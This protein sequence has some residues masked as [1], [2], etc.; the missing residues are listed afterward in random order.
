MSKLSQAW[1][2]GAW[3]VWGLLPLAIL[4]WLLSSLRRWCY[5]SGILSS[6]KP[7]AFIIVIGNIS[8][9]GNG[10]TP[11]VIA[12]ANWFQQRNIRVGVLSRGYGGNA[13]S[14]PHSVNATD[15]AYLVG[16][17]PK[18]IANRTGVPVVIDPTRTRGAAY[19][20][21]KFNCDVILCDD[22]LQHYALKRDFELVVMDNRGVG[23]GKLLPMGPLREGQWRLNTVDAIILNNHGERQAG[24]LNSVSVPQ[25][26]MSLLAQ[27]CVSVMDSSHIISI[28]KFREDYARF[29][30]LAGI[31]APERFFNYLAQHNLHAQKKVSFNDH[32][33]FERA[34]IPNGVVLM[35]EKD[36]VKVK[37]IGHDQCWYLPI[38]AQLP[39][40]FY[41][42]LE[43]ALPQ[44][45]KQLRSQDGV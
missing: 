33:S 34:D 27:N 6:S 3:W 9:G 24:I 45:I 11:V 10:K 26:P 37:S 21:D 36:A 1:Y 4:F 43:K 20:K 44:P 35:T 39:D 42:Q 8:V 25:Y 13:T 32:H 23:N 7:D 5:R 19:L 31:G 28:D 40:S 22:G 15:P 12:L 14:F 30:A 17:E 29:T 41:L 38:V 16:D 18:L 2:K